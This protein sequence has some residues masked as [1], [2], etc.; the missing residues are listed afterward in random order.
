[1]LGYTSPDSQPHPFAGEQ[2]VYQVS[3]GILKIGTLKMSVSDCKGP[4]G[5]PAYHASWT[6]KS[7]GFASK[8]YPVDD[9][10][11]TYFY[12]ENLVPYQYIKIIN[13]GKTHTR[14]HVVFNRKDKTFTYYEKAPWVE[15]KEKVPQD[16][17]GRV[18]TVGDIPDNTRDEFSVHYFLRT[19]EINE[20]DRFVLPVVTDAN[21]LEARFIV[22]NGGEIKCGLGKI[23]TWRIEPKV[24]WKG[25][26]WPYGG[27]EMWLSRS[28]PLNIPVKIKIDLAFGSLTGRL[29]SAIHPK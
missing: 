10:F 23:P 24:T 8:L 7:E 21:L 20:N 16:P 18:L 28:H 19:L 4:N 11:E 14:R 26:P 17:Q 29:I 6:L 2:L 9:L 27:M 25:E 15:T 13:E 3:W 5:H 1:M 22:K 12:Q